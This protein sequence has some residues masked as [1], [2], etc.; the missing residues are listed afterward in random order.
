MELNTFY[1]LKKTYYNE[2]KERYTYESRWLNGAHHWCPTIE[3]V[4]TAYREGNL[5][6]YEVLFFF[7][8]RHHDVLLVYH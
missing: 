1:Y 5:Q 4:S 3:N 2:T 8:G 7:D 6:N